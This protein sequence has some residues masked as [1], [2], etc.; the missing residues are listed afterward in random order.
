MPVRKFRSVEEMNTPVWRLPGE[1]TLFLAI[2]RLWE[3]G[4]RTSTRRFPTG[5]RKHS[6]IEEMSMTQER[7]AAGKPLT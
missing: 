7:R 5:V 4:R 6:S 1:P 2:A 3:L